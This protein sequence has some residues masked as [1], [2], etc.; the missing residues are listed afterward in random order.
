M[1]ETVEL[2]LRGRV[3]LCRKGRTETLVSLV[4]ERINLGLHDILAH[5]KSFVDE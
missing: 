3:P 4:L 2:R 5:L 1:R